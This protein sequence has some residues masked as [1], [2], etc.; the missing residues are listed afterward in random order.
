MFGSKFTTKAGKMVFNSNKSL[1]KGIKHLENINY[2]V[3]ALVQR[4]NNEKNNSATQL[5]P[6]TTSE[7]KI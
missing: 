7:V 4:M 6:T 5:M 1:A 3:F 2:Y